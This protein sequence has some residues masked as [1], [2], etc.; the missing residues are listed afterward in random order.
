MQMA[1]INYRNTAD[2]I[3]AIPAPELSWTRRMMLESD[4]Y[5]GQLEQLNLDE[6]KNVQAGLRLLMFDFFG[7]V[8]YIPTTSEGKPCSGKRYYTVSTGLDWIF[9]CQAVILGHED[10]D[11]SATLQP[12][13]ENGSGV[14]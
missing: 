3:L 12:A 11:E 2:E 8:G 5:L 6:I 13:T 1:E 14:P 4:K 10:D 7:R 9:D